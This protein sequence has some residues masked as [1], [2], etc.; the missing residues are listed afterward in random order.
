MKLK[1]KQEY[2]ETYIST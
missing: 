1:F 2:V